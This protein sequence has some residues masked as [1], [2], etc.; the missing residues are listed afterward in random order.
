MSAKTGVRNI[1]TPGGG[2]GNAGG[3][4]SI[5]GNGQAG[6]VT[7]GPEGTTVSGSVQVGGVDVAGTYTRG[8]KDQKKSGEFTQIGSDKDPGQPVTMAQ[9][10]S[11]APVGVLLGVLLLLFARS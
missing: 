4:I 1:N 5:S 9:V 6:T 2:S 3:S 10:K 7:I 8:S 11:L